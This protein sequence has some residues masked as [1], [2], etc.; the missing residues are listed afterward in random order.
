MAESTPELMTLKMCACR[1]EEAGALGR[2]SGQAQLDGTDD[3]R[4]KD[5]ILALNTGTLGPHG[6]A[7]VEDCVR[8]LILDY[9]RKT[10]SC[11]VID[12]VN[13]FCKVPGNAGYD[14]LVLMF[15]EYEDL[16]TEGSACR[17]GFLDGPLRQMVEDAD[18]GR[19]RVDVDG[20]RVHQH[21][22]SDTD[23]ETDTDTEPDTEP[24]T[25]TEPEPEPETEPKT[26]P[27]TK[28]KTEPQT[29]PQTEPPG[30][31]VPGLAAA[32][33]H[34]KPWW[35][36]GDAIDAGDACGHLTGKE[37]TPLPPCE[38]GDGV[39]RIPLTFHHHPIELL[40]ASLRHV[41][42]S[43]E[44]KAGLIEGYR[45]R[46]PIG[47]RSLRAPASSTHPLRHLVF[48]TPEGSPQLAKVVAW[49]DAFVKL[50]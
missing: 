38:D 36:Y 50:Y 31:E 42:F 23:T 40:W 15:L 28:P 27:E 13:D 17:C 1:S 26:K 33:Q 11:R 22:H 43:E 18:A 45:K 14:Y 16:M 29:E 7:L 12:F 4:I 35:S 19:V 21:S 2:L 25:K 37:D 47:K 5:L 41:P 46:H 48:E 8:F 39:Q 44:V 6:L 9:R 49:C 3:Q 10:G 24:K 20:R 30:Q 34:L 32:H